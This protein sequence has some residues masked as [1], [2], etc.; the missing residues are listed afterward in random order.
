MRK[1][2]LLA[3]ILLF[4]PVLLVDSEAAAFTVSAEVQKSSVVDLPRDF[5]RTYINDLSIYPRFFPDIVSVKKLNGTESE[6]HYNVEA[7]Q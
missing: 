7:L 4:S 5:V 1:I 6:W 2:L 3:L